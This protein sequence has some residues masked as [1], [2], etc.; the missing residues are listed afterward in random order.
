[1]SLNIFSREANVIKQKTN[2]GIA[3]AGRVSFCERTSGNELQGSK[4]ARAFFAI[5]LSRGKKVDEIKASSHEI[6]FA[7]RSQTPLYYHSEVQ[8]LSKEPIRSLYR[9]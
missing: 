7:I 6:V 1:M 3:I 8:N 9:P 4:P 5:F 2:E